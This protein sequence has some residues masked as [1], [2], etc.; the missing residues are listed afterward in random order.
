MSNYLRYPTY[1]AAMRQSQAFRALSIFLTAEL[2]QF[3]LSLSEWKLLGH[4]SE[5]NEMTPSEIAILLNVKLPISTRILKSLVL[6]KC[7]VR[8]ISHK[9]NRVIHAHI[10]KKGKN[11]VNEVE[12]HLRQEM[13]NFLSD[14]DRQDLE[15]YLKVVVQLSRKIK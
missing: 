5:T 9:D 1:E 11:L 8:R 14:I 2:K 10:T 12:K 13:K 3:D 15:T 4:L 7:I 6:K